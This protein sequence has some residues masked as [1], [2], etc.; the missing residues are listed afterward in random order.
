MEALRIVMERKKEKKKKT[1]EF[2]FM[3]Q[4]VGKIKTTQKCN[5]LFFYLL[6]KRKF[7]PLKNM[8]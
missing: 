4:I 5:P 7:N 3:L 6:I 2:N 1:R 8:F